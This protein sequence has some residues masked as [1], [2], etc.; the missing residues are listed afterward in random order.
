MFYGL[1]NSVHFTVWPHEINDNMDEGQED[2]LTQM[3]IIS[4]VNNSRT[5]NK[6]T[7][8]KSME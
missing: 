3:D 7:T 4:K 1:Q 2:K 5:P 8:L 6:F